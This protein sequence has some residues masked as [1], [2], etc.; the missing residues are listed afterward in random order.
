MTDIHEIGI[1]YLPLM[2]SQLVRINSTKSD[3]KCRSQNFWSDASAATYR[4]LKGRMT[5]VGSLFVCVFVI[6]TH[7][8]VRKSAYIMSLFSFWLNGGN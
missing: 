8:A 3:I 5:C 6:F 1:D 2:S 7:Y 4:H